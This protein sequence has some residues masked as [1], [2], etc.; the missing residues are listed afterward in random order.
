MT[1]SSLNFQRLRELFDTKKSDNVQKFSN[2]KYMKMLLILFKKEY[3]ESRPNYISRLYNKFNDYSR[4]INNHNDFKITRKEYKN[5]QRN[6]LIFGSSLLDH[7]Q[8]IPNMVNEME[9]NPNHHS[10]WIHNFFNYYFLNEYIDYQQDYKI[11]ILITFNI[12]KYYRKKFEHILSLNPVEIFAFFRQYIITFV[13]QR[14]ESRIFLTYE[15][16][17]IQMAIYFLKT[18]DK[19]MESH[20]YKIDLP[21]NY[22]EILQNLINNID[23]RIRRDCNKQFFHILYRNL[24]LYYSEFPKPF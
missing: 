22:N 23:R 19:V 12:L 3:R 9:I 10:K 14:Y 8:S 15:F 17:I 18:N 2:E 4:K 5:L 20:I 13:N 6:I 11:V 21:Y 24:R 16:S 7:F 1:Y